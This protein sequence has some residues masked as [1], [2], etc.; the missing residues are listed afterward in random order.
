MPDCICKN[1]EFNQIDYEHS[2]DTYKQINKAIIK[3]RKNWR[4]YKKVNAN[5]FFIRL[6]VNKNL[7]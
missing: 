7:T 4:L 5:T 1:L 3:T 2:I 6:N